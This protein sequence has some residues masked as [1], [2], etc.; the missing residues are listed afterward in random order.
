MS[1]R[2]MKRS[3][4]ED[5]ARH[6]EQLRTSPRLRWLFFEIT[7]RCNLAC[8]HCGSSCTSAGQMLTAEDIENTLKTIPSDKPAV[9]LTGGEPMLH[10]DFFA[11]AER[12]RSRGFAWGMTT[13]GTL[14]EKTAAAKLREAGMATVSVS[15]DGMEQSHDSLRQK[16]GAWRLALRGLQALQEAGFAPQVTT[17]LHRENFDDL[18][19]LYDLLC[20]TGIKS[21]RPINVEP[22][23]RACESKNLLLL[24]EQFARLLSYIRD[25]RFDRSCKMEV[26]F[27]CSHYLGVD[28]ERM[29]RD[30]YFLC[31]ASIL[32]ASVRSNGD[33]CACLDIENRKELVQ[34]NIRT[35][36]FMDVWRNRFQ[37]FR[38]D[39]TAGCFQCIACPERFICGGDSTHTWDFENNRP[40]LCY[41]D[42]RQ[43][44]E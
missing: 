12:V 22:I 14:I 37:V 25:K 30:H 7:N 11:I 38:R 4:L 39:R 27:G 40:L 29:V 9:C 6:R 10:P 13:N 17:V 8:R 19:P 16:R 24:P 15:L 1:V 5:I 32:T 33:I 35:D 41:Q 43:F 20:K 26:T 18:E 42:Y 3:Q 28:F 21:W 2:D 36:N 23:G 44:L 31:G 34:G